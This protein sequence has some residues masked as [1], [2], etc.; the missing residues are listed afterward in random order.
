MKQQEMSTPSQTTAPDLPWITTTAACTQQ[1]II[2]IF[3]ALT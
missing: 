1:R 3:K 2:L